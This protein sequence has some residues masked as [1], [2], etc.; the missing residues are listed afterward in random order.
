MT[1]NS[2]DDVS[3]LFVP[4]GNDV[5]PTTF[6]VGPWRPD[7]VHGSAVA[8]LFAAAL[9]ETSATVARVTMDLLGAVPMRP[10][11][12]SVT[13]V[14]GGRRVRRRQALLQHGERVVA[15]AVALLVADSADLDLPERD[16]S[17]PWDPPPKDL[18]LLP[19]S[20]AGWAG[21][22]SQSMA[23]QTS[24]EGSQTMVGW[25]RL[26]H[27]AIAGQSLTGLQRALAAADYTSGGTAVVLPLKQWTFVSTDLTVNLARKPMGDWIGLAAKSRLGTTGI[28][29]ATSVLHDAAGGLGHCSQ[30]QFIE[31]RKAQ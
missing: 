10:M 7:S 23:L 20:R 11:Q 8:A 16:E 29:I 12:L 18:S 27:P 30:T 21:F 14:E 22:E 24:R 6:A 1:P 3:A 17:A 26:L 19:V 4:D 15:R 25:F 5:V 31:A 13:D 9:D 28:G 2:R